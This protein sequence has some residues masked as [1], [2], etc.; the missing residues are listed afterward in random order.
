[1]QGAQIAD[2]SLHRDID[3]CV[4]GNSVTDASKFDIDEPVCLSFMVQHRNIEKIGRKTEK[5]SFYSK[6][7]SIS[8]L[9]I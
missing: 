4:R 1:M 9:L 5:K 7:V 2:T 8:F 6:F 3:V